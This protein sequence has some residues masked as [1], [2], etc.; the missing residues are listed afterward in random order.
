MVAADNGQLEI[1]K[2]LVEVGG[3]KMLMLVEKVCVYAYAR[4]CLLYTVGC[5]VC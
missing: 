1:V 2:Y 4:Y 3:K 5:V